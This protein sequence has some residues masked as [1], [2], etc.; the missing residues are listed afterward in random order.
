MVIFF[1]NHHHK[2]SLY[3]I[4]KKAHLSHEQNAILYAFLKLNITDGLSKT[5]FHGPAECW[6]TEMEQSSSPFKRFT[7]TQKPLPAG[8][9][10]NQVNGQV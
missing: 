9:T 2:F 1:V 6:C 7:V 3:H 4:E 5:I 10:N 8:A